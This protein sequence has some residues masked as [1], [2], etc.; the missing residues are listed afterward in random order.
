MVSAVFDIPK[1]LSL[2]E[3]P[4]AILGLL[5]EIVNLQSKCDSCLDPGGM[6][7]LELGTLF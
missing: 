2:S 4:R 7:M 5:L 3:L 6:F 1:T